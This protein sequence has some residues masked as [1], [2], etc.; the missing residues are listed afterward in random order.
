MTLA[1]LNYPQKFSTGEIALK[2]EIM[3]QP[4]VQDFIGALHRW[5]NTQTQNIFLN[6]KCQRTIFTIE[7]LH[8]GKP[9][10]LLIYR[11]Q[12]SELIIQG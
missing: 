7:A 2:L 4:I 12:G 8:F 5:Q 9:V 10:Q 1:I 11:E 3:N 6:G